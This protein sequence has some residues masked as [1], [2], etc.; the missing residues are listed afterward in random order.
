VNGPD[1]TGRLVPPPPPRDALPQRRRKKGGGGH[2]LWL[3][4]LAFAAGIGLGIVAYQYA[5]DVDFY[6]DYWVALMFS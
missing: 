6:F 2:R 5:P 1:G 4:P 3:W